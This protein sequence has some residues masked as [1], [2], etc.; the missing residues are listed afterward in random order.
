[1]PTL[2]KEWQ[3]KNKEAVAAKSLTPGMAAINKGQTSIT[4]YT[5]QGVLDKS[6]PLTPKNKDLINEESVSNGHNSAR[7][8]WRLRQGDGR[9]ESKKQ[10]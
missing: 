7:T 4:S 9:A 6:T 2:T 10:R 8:T 5:P 3:K 1:M